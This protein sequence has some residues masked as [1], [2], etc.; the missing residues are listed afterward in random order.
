MKKSL[1]A[2]FSVARVNFL[3]LSIILVFLGTAIAFYDGFLN[4]PRAILALV[5]LILLHMSVNVLNEYFDYKSGLDFKTAK[6]PFSGGSGTL[7]A[8]LLDPKKVYIFGIVCF[9]SGASIG[10]IFLLITKLLLVPIIVLGAIFILFYTTHLAKWLLGEL[11][12]GMGLGLLPVL[13]SYVVQAESYSLKAL[14]AS[15]PSGILVFNLLFLNEFPDLEADKEVGRKNL[16]I[17][18]GRR[19]ARW[20]YSFLTILTYLWI[21]FASLFGIMPLPTLL[22]LLTVPVG[23]KAIKITI[24]NYDERDRL[25]PALGANV[26]VVLV[27]QLLLGIGYSIGALL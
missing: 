10:A 26:V 3:P 11:A 17:L 4:I 14:I 23:F 5:G 25:I 8:G 7:P 22:G 24:E 15:V 19:K 13:G 9:L 27:T 20:V 21:V 12:A 18:L 1:K 2:W 16:V 6:T